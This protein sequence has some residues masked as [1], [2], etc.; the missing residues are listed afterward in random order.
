M[1]ICLESM[2]Q[3]TND[4]G[5]NSSKGRSINLSAKTFR[6]SS[7]DKTQILIKSQ[8]IS[9]MTHNCQC[10]IQE[11]DHALREPKRTDI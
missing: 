9:F 6:W 4:V 1:Y 5:W 7:H 2:L 8:I 10:S 11:T 3:Y